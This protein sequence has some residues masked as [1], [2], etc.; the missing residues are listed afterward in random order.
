MALSQKWKRR[1]RWTC[2]R[3][4]REYFLPDGPSRVDKPDVRASAW[5]MLGGLKTCETCAAARFK[6]RHI[7]TGGVLGETVC[8]VSFRRFAD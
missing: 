5:T 1:Q 8:D 2:E 4:G 6:R 7:R 3:C